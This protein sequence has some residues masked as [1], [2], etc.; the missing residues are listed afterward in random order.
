[1]GSK[2][3]KTNNDVVCY[4]IHCYL[5]YM[6]P[7]LKQYSNVSISVLDLSLTDLFNGRDFIR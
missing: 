1:M 6:K 2:D 4:K 5:S 7:L 3:Q